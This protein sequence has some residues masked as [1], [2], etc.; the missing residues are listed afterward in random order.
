MTRGQRAE[1]ARAEESTFDWRTFSP[2]DVPP[3]LQASLDVFVESGYHGATTRQL[4]MRAGLSVPGLYHHYESKHA[5]LVAIMRLAMA[6]LY[7]RSLAALAEAGDSVEAQLRLQVECLVLFHAHRGDL[8]F[9]ASSEIRALEGEAR[10]Q[11]IAARDR[12]QRI[13]D[14]IVEEGVRQGVF[15]SEYTEETSRAI[16]TMCTA[17]AQWF[18]E[19]GPL[20]AEELALRYISI[21]K[22]AL[23]FDSSE[24]SAPVD[25]APKS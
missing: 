16:V 9:V 7:A 14:A 13:L 23:H 25:P 15:R 10:Q 4:A 17:V 21:A 8:A 5:I 2:D 11:H 24:G 19:S 18:R 12:Q 22:S 20:S 3:L 6:D 1:P